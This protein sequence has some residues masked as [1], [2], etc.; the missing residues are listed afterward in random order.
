MVTAASTFSEI[1]AILI[2]LSRPF[3]VSL[4]LPKFYDITNNKLIKGYERNR[5]QK[6]LRLHIANAQVSTTQVLTEENG[7][8]IEKHSVI[9][10]AVPIG[11]CPEEQLLWTH[12]DNLSNMLRANPETNTNGESNFYLQWKQMVLR[13]I[14]AKVCGLPFHIPIKIHKLDEVH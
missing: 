12:Y 13:S 11:F 7:V 6:A 10:P 8:D 3:W 1:C 14:I 9:I 4:R 2:P 5:L